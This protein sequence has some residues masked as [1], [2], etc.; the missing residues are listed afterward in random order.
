MQVLFAR[1]IIDSDREQV[2]KLEIGYS[3]AVSVFLNG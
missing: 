3:D 1:T 2:K